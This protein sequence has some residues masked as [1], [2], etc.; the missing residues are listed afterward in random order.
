MHG[1]YSDFLLLPLDN[2]AKS[3][4]ADLAHASQFLDDRNH[5][6]HGLCLSI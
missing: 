6:D 5:T 3:S 4:F 1:V 2:E